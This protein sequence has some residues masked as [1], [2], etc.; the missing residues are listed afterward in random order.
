MARR[1]PHRD[2]ARRAPAT[3]APAARRASG[4]ADAPAWTQPAMLW[5]IAALLLFTA[6]SYLPSLS[7]QLTNW[8]DNLYV[9]DDLLIR[10]VS[11]SNLV[12]VATRPVAFNYHPLTVWSLQANYLAGGLD[13]W[14]YHATNLLLHLLNVVLVFQLLR[15]LGR[16]SAEA[17]LAG[18]LMF[19]VHPM[20]VESVAW[21][22]ERKDVLCAFFLLLMSLAWLRGLRDR[23]HRWRWYFAALGSC[24]LALLSKPAAIVAPALLLA[25]D[26]LERRPFTVRSAALE[27]LPFVALSILFGIITLRIQAESLAVH[28]LQV[29]KPTDKLLVASYGLMMYLIKFL[30]PLRLSAFYPYP[31]LTKPWPVAFLVAPVVVA[32]V[33]AATIWSARRTR[34]VPG[35]MLVFAAVLAP[36]LQLVSVGLAVMADRYSS[37]AQVGLVLIVTAGYEKL[38]RRWTG[39]PDRVHALRT[40]V[41]LTGLTFAVLTW[42]RCQVWQTSETLW[43]DVIT[44][45]PTWGSA[46]VSR[47]ADRISRGDLVGAQRDL[48]RAVA[49][50]PHDYQAYYNRGL[51]DQRRND[52]PRAV[53]DYTLAIAADGARAEAWINRA[54]IQSSQARYPEAIADYS[55]AIALDPSDSEIWFNR[56]ATHFRAGSFRPALADYERGLQINPSRPE[57]RFYLGVCQYRLGAYQAAVDAYDR[58]ITLD[59]AQGRYFL[60]RALSLA[61]LHRRAEAANDARE[62]MALGQTVDEGFLRSLQ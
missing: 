48:D 55:R 53:E 4:R 17:T 35:G 45:H 37:V 41:V 27:K 19:A 43:T 23:A 13:P 49:L 30:V 54:G 15:M 51:L 60:Y 31:D 18:A 16:G 8:D 50:A 32:A 12:Q 62:A 25:L 44:K 24:V 52:L 46:Y 61:A 28:A 1:K 3:V 33:I 38:L 11:V 47:G 29:L 59:S 21:V 36:V 9:T 42:Q 56:A 22:S 39:R 34:I 14:P 57:E 10:Q 7:A 58:A 5:G 40:A 2:E 6:V 20:H 26:Y